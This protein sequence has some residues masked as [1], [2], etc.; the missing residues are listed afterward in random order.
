MTCSIRHNTFQNLVLDHQNYFFKIAFNYVSN[1]DSAKELVQ[2]TVEVLLKNENKYTL[3]TNFKAWAS[4]IMRNIFIN[5]YRKCKSRAP[6][7]TEYRM[8]NALKSGTNQGV[9]QV[10][11]EELETIVSSLDALHRI[12]FLMHYEGYSYREI[13]DY[14]NV[15]LGT[16]KSR[17]CIARRKL[18][19]KLLNKG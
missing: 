17:I 7:M 15:P 14:F 5:H 19:E 3:G 4:V 13:S 18:R 2:D 10:A 16:I 11:L 9:E 1:N 12:P 8:A 6:R